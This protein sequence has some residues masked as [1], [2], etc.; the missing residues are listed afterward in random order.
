MND[1][2]NQNI[3]RTQNIA[4]ISTYEQFVQKVGNRNMNLFRKKEKGDIYEIE[5]EV[6]DVYPSDKFTIKKSDFE[7]FSAKLQKERK[8]KEAVVIDRTTSDI[9]AI[10]EATVTTAT[11]KQEGN[12]VQNNVI[13]NKA[14]TTIEQ[15]SKP[16]GYA[17]YIRMLWQLEF[18]LESRE[19]AVKKLNGQNE[20]GKDTLKRTQEKIKE[21]KKKAKTLRKNTE[22]YE[23]S[24]EKSNKKDKKHADIP[25]FELDPVDWENFVEIYCQL[26]PLEYDTKKG[27]AGKYSNEANLPDGDT[28]Q[29]RKSIKE[30]LQTYHK[31]VEFNKALKDKAI[32]EIFRNDAELTR[33]FLKSVIDG[34]MQPEFRDYY[35]LAALQFGQNIANYPFLAKQSIVCH[36]QIIDPLTPHWIGW[37]T[38]PASFSHPQRGPVNYNNLDWG[39]TFKVGGI[40]GTIRKVF[41]QFPNLTE[42]QKQ[43][44]SGLASL[45]IT[46]FSLFKWAQWLLKG[47]DKGW[48]KWRQ[49]GLTLAG[50]TFWTQVL[51]GENPISLF[52]KLMN[53]GLSFDE[54]KNRLQNSTTLFGGDRATA[55]YMRDQSL[56]QCFG[57]ITPVELTTNMGNRERDPSSWTAFYQSLS[58][59][60]G[61][62][63]AVKDLWPTYNDQTQEKLR[64]WLNSI[65]IWIPVYKALENTSFKDINEIQKKNQKFV[66]EYTIKRGLKVDGD[67]QKEI[68]TYLTRYNLSDPKILEEMYEKGLFKANLD[69][70]ETKRPED[71]DYLKKTSE[72]I[73]KKLNSLNKEQQNA[74]YLW[75]KLFYNER[76]IANKPDFSFE[77]EG[78]KIY[79]ISHIN[80]D[81]TKQKLEINV[82]DKTLPHFAKNGKVLT[83]PD[84]REMIRIAYLSNG[85]MNITKDVPTTNSAPF[86]FRSL[87]T[88]LRLQ[89]WLPM[90]GSGIYFDDKKWNEW[91]LDT[92]MVSYGSFFGWFGKMDDVSELIHR[93]P[94]VYSDY[95]NYLFKEQWGGHIENQETFESI[96][97]NGAETKEQIENLWLNDHDSYL[98]QKA[99]NDIYQLYG[100]EAKSLG[101]H[102][103]KEGED[104]FFKSY[105]S[106]IKISLAKKTIEGLT[107]EDEEISFVNNGELIKA[108]NLINAIKHHCSGKTAKSN[109]DPETREKIEEDHP[110]YLDR[111]WDL[112][113]RKIWENII[114]ATGIHR[115]LSR[116][117]GL[118]NAIKNNSPTLHQHKSDLVHYLNA[119]TPPFWVN[120][121]Q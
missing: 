86:K 55:K 65:G 36:R 13:E 103:R 93:N 107:S 73:E 58:Q 46:G 116:L 21:W 67:K 112:V 22:K 90:T 52:S 8:E 38:V 17:E 82:K 56:L 83:F 75:A 61:D 118:N 99:C 51:L 18:E 88:T 89:T 39:E 77:Q 64:T 23:K 1:I 106:E 27:M 119:S 9:N 24:I 49:K 81:G 33:K 70:A 34:K 68:N 109:I 16:I 14:N 80:E 15:L 44:R 66:D 100:E 78:D 63:P 121:D 59:Q 57:G 30:N 111:A 50:V 79:L 102:L 72:N 94:E 117:P 6:D 26:E 105:D 60:Y 7:T 3:D 97:D 110:F 11:A 41:D 20:M 87:W 96:S 104:V 69:A 114:V 37:Y 47:K 35:Q 115:T 101:I 53:G 12:I 108:T 48:M 98:I 2:Y 71:I 54:F 40:N 19:K 113:F 85:L 10:R 32:L 74:L 42:K 62:Y 45:V 5:M 92:Q 84:L 4:E 25:R 120:I 28:K 91:G 76:S 43:T 31:Q 29:V 95:L